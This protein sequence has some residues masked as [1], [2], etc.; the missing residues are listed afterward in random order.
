[1][2]L[3]TRRVAVIIWIL[4]IGFLFIGNRIATANPNIM[5]DA[6]HYAGITG[7]VVSAV[8]TEIIERD[9]W[10][11]E[12]VPGFTISGT[13][14]IFEAR[15]TSAGRRGEHVTA[16]HYLD[17]LMSVRERE[18]GQGDRILLAYDYGAGQYIFVDYVR[19]NYIAILG[20]VLFGLMILFGGARGFNSIV[21]LGFTCLAIFMVLV[22]AILGGRNIYLTAIAVCVYIIVFTLLIVAG[23][24][25]KSLS[26]ILGCLGGVAVAALIMRFMG[27]I[28]N[29]TGDVDD[30][31]RFLF[32]LPLERPISLGAIVFAGV[33]IGAV[34]AI[35]D[36]AMSIAS[37][38]WEVRRAGENLSFGRIF[39]S[40]LNIGKDILGTMLNTLILAYIGSSLS[41]ILVIAFYTHATS[42]LDIFN[43]E[44]I[45]VEFLRA[46]IGSFG[47]FLAIPL[48]SAICGCLYS[49]ENRRHESPRGR[50][51][52]PKEDW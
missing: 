28:L 13:M 6:E 36:V 25:K 1:M 40:G 7:D 21:A 23:P 46:I 17:D 39:R 35:M 8:V 48:T 31:S 10:R 47:I 3:R 41:L 26:A 24:S 30:S 52:E 34:G 9:E 33:V 11:Q 27:V 43:R 42:L 22:P 51:S 20:A 15:I 2:K 32:A 5:D 45:A 12:I 19:I 16:E 4:A 37:S 50:R 44:M 38:L 18:V 14:I 49:G 29:L